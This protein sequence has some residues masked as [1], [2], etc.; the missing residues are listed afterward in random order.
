LGSGV[1]LAVGT[2][3]VMAVIV[4]KAFGISTPSQLLMTVSDE[5]LRCSQ[6]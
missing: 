5:S 6:E 2:F 1:F 4:I 3:P